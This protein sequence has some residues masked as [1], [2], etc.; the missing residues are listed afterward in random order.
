MSNGGKLLQRARKKISHGNW[1]V[2]RASMSIFD[3]WAVQFALVGILDAFNSFQNGN[4]AELYTLIIV[5]FTLLCRI[6]NFHCLKFPNIQYSPRTMCSLHVRQIPSNRNFHWAQLC[7]N[8]ILF[9]IFNVVVIVVVLLY[10]KL[11]DERMDNVENEWM[12]DGSMKL[13]GYCVR[14]FN[15]R[16]RKKSIYN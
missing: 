14:I 16:T 5:Y 8:F 2:W 12:R 4:S 15:N 13:V 10:E 7:S 1:M 3:Y 9:S 11:I 6:G